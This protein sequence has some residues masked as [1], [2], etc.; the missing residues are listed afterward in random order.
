[1]TVIADGSRDERVAV[2]AAD[3]LEDRQGVLDRRRPEAQALPGLVEL[4]REHPVHVE[5]AGLDRQVGR[6]E[7]AAA[8]LVDDVERADQPDVVDE[9]GDV[10]RLAGLGRGR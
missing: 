2:D 9:V 7:R 8:L 4:D 1:M 3:E 5:V 10:A 6:L